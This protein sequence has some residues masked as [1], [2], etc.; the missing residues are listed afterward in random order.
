[1]FMFYISQLKQMLEDLYSHILSGLGLSH[2]LVENV[3]GYAVQLLPH[4]NFAVNLCSCYIFLSWI[5]IE[6]IYS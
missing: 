4:Y 3:F 2:W 1:M 5:D 6:D